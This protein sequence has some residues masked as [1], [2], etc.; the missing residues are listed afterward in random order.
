[1]W[2]SIKNRARQHWFFKVLALV[3][4]V[5]VWLIASRW[6]YETVTLTVPVELTVREGKIVKAIDPPVVTVSL[7][8]PREEMTPAEARE[9]EVKVVHD[10]TAL[11]TPGTVV[12]NLEE[13]DVRR[14][15]R[16]RVTGISPG[17][18]TAE[19]DR[20]EEKVLPIRVTFRG[21]PRRGYR[22]AET[23]VYPPE[24]KV[25]GPA[26][27]LETMSEIPTEPITVMGRQVTF[28]SQAALQSVSPFV[29]DPLPEVNVIVVMGRELK[30]RVFRRV[31]V[32][33]LRDPIRFDQ[34]RLEPREVDLHL[35]GPEPVM[36]GLT[37]AAVR[38]YVDIA[39][40]EPGTWELPLQTALPPEVTLERSDPARV[41]VFLDRGAVR[42]P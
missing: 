2:E 29:R 40:L 7:E 24:V 19:I 39:G 38:V 23:R 37:A 28:D 11:D 18:I 27:I 8:Y 20:L 10:L 32:D 31:R 36:D 4:A 12:F 21:S 5:V 33:I 6:V 16:T 41:K 30:E 26:G 13:G 9:I 15:R 14:P 1:M 22:V 35:K 25:T 3:I 17:R 34:V 42:A